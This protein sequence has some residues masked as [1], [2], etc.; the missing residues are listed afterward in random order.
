MAT[1]GEKRPYSELDRSRA[2]ITYH[3]PTKSFDRLFKGSFSIF[4]TAT[5]IVD[6]IL[7]VE[8]SLLEVKEVVRRKLDLP[9]DA[10]IR[11]EQVRGDITIALEDRM[12]F[13][14]RKCL[15]TYFLLL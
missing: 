5:V 14:C 11:L 9:P 3:A 15:S 2:I 4:I 12:P 7:S 13:Q 6:S 10:I 1:L 8:E